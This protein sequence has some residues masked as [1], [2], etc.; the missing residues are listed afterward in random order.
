MYEELDREVRELAG[1]S[2]KRKDNSQKNYRYGSNP[3]SIKLAGQLVPVKVPRIRGPEGEVRLQSYNNLHH[4]EE[5][6]EMMF[7]QVL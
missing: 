3:G 7:R 6:N 4:G 2:Y 5:L 1:Q